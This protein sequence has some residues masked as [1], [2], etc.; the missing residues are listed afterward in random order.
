LPLVIL[1]TVGVPDQELFR[2][3]HNL[4]PPLS[5]SCSPLF[6]ESNHINIIPR[7]WK[8]IFIFFFEEW[9]LANWKFSFSSPSSPSLSSARLSGEWKYCRKEFSSVENNGDCLME[10]PLAVFKEMFQLDSNGWN[11]EMQA[12]G[13][14]DQGGWFKVSGNWLRDLVE[15]I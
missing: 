10:V 8:L 7:E 9:S 4:S 13:L 6:F 1:I 11:G 15:G 12:P 5:P 2:W 3:H 14:I